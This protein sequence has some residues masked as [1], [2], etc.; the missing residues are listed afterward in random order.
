M[1]D[2]QFVHIEI[3][4]YGAKRC[5]CAHAW[6]DLPQFVKDKFDAFVECG[7]LAHGFLRLRC[8]DCGHDKL[9]AF[10]R[11]RRGFCP[12]CGVRHMAQTSAHLID[13]GSDISIRAC[14]PEVPSSN[15]TGS[16]A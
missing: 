4:H 8:G 11:K 5:N 2:L 13:H 1:M 9:V 7:I 15:R 16:W 14:T 3:V 12:S 6:P 10:S